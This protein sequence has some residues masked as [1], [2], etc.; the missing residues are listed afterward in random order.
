MWSGRWYLVLV[1]M[2]AMWLGAG[3]ALAEEALSPEQMI[4]RADA[5]VQKA[6]DLHDQALAALKKA[7]AS[8]DPSA[9]ADAN[10]VLTTIKGVLR[11]A[12]HDRMAL[13]EAIAKGNLEEARSIFDGI[14]VAEE[15]TNAVD[16]A[17]ATVG[18]SGIDASVEGTD[19]LDVG[20][21]DGQPTLD[22][23]DP[24]SE[25]TGSYDS[26]Q[27]DRSGYTTDTG[28]NTGGKTNDGASSGADDLLEGSPTGSALD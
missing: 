12:E 20:S 4:A 2:L 16:S 14:L 6:Q 3:S 5:V 27:D 25:Y 15:A 18:G 1:T 17:L 11:K 21:D 13:K 23:N 26:R 22:P 10:S 9:I 19:A 7:Q 28:G 8:G 24:L